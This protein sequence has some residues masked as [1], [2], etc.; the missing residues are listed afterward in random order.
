VNGLC[1]C[2]CGESTVIAKQTS[3]G[4]GNVAGQPQRFKLGHYSRTLKK[5][6]LYTRSMRK[7]YVFLY[8]PSHPRAGK[9]GF[10]AEHILVASTALGKPLPA[11]SQV[12]HVNGQP[13]DNRP[14]NLVICQD[15]AY[16]KLLHVRARVKA[17][18]GDPNTDRICS[19][20]Q[21]VLPVVAFHAKRSD[22]NRECKKCVQ[23]RSGFKPWCPGG[24]GRPPQ[25][26]WL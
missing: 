4:R 5:H 10:I 14:S 25:G 16:H 23:E 24:K 6:D 26:V 15:A 21:R 3:V 8:V 9:S 19:T 18:G 1:E 11:G 13:A 12:H 17:A 22:A 20:C 2:G 7:G